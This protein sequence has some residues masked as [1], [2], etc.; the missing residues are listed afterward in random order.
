VKKYLVCILALSLFGL[1]A[2][3]SSGVDEVQKWTTIAS[4]TF[5]GDPRSSQVTKAM[6]ILTSTGATV[7]FVLTGGAMASLVC[8]NMGGQDMCM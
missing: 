1:I 2:F 3:A 8:H 4:Q 7:T 5:K 6:V